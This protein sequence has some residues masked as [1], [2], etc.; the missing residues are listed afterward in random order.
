MTIYI[1]IGSVLLLFALCMALKSLTSHPKQQDSMLKQRA[2]FNINEQLT[3]TRLK[4][5]L[6]KSIILA[7]VTY[8]ALLTTKYHRTRTKYQNMIADFVILDEFY[9]VIAI[10]AVDDASSIRHTES[11]DYEDALL[12]MA[13]YQ[14]FRYEDVPEYY[15]LRRDFIGDSASPRQEQ[16]I[17]H[18][19]QYHFERRKNKVLT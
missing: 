8:D 14:V 7:H 9:Q 19:V 12:T 10:V 15:Q 1:L 13:G 2:V 5:I 18:N 4:E 11:A 17:K 3:F 6:P 16:A